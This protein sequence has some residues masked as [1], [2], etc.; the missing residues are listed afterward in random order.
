[1][2]TATALVALVRDR[3]LRG[4]GAADRLGHGLPHLAH[5]R[6]RLARPSRRHRRPRLG[7]VREPHLHRRGVG[8]RG[9]GGARAPGACSSGGRDLTAAVVGPRGRRVRPGPARR[10]RRARPRR[11]DRGGRPLPPLRGARGHRRGAPPPRR[12]ARGR[13]RGPRPRRRCCACRPLLVA[14][15]AVVLVT[16]TVVTG[17]GPHGGDEAADRLPFAVRAVVPVHGAAVWALLARRDGRCSPGPS[18]ATSPRR[19]LGRGRLLHRRDRRP[20]RARLPAVLHRRARGPRRRC[21]CSARSL[22]WVAVLRF[23]LALHE[24]VP[25]ADGDGRPRPVAVAG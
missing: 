16:G 25:D 23:H 15:A 7:R 18:A 4:R 11:P 6:G 21:T 10:A 19:S 8:G 12:A 14:S 1:M 2:I 17:S 22:V 24:G 3:R 9:P 5:L 13:P 20:G